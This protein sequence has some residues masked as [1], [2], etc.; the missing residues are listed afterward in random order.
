MVTSCRQTERQDIFNSSPDFVIGSDT[1][2]LGWGARCSP[3]SSGRTWSA[4][5]PRLHINTYTPDGLFCHRKS[6]ATHVHLLCAIAFGQRTRSP[7]RRSL[8]GPLIQ[9]PSGSS[10]TSGTSAWNA[11]SSRL[12]D[13]PQTIPIGWQIGFSLPD[14]F[15]RLATA[16]V[17]VPDPR[18]LR[19]SFSMD[20]FVPR[21]NHQFP[22]SYNRRPDPEAHHVDA[23]HQTWSQGTHYAFPCSR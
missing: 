7:V 15:Q 12:R 16:P 22:R 17:R 18:S 20:L 4:E 1:S 21:I 19:G 2:R 14:R 11:T 8:G 9:N 13:M 3:S 23:L 5:N 10:K 6:V